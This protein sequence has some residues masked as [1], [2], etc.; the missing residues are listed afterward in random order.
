MF[1]IPMRLL[2]Q[3][4]RQD[5]ADP[6]W[7]QKR[8]M[9]EAPLADFPNLS[10]LIVRWWVLARVSFKSHPKSP[11]LQASR[12]TFGSRAPA[13]DCIRGQRLQLSGLAALREDDVL[14]RLQP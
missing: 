7:K 13:A 1:L 8:G 4:D 6:M 9:E 12:P 2:E 11:R 10:R 3:H 14:V 5:P